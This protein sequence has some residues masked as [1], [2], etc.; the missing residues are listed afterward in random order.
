MSK[1]QNKA[2]Q[3]T[4]DADKLAR[5]EAFVREG[6]WDKIRSTAGRIP[7]S[8]DAVAAYFCAIDRQTPAYIKAMLFGAIAYF[9]MPMDVIPDFIAGL[10]FTDDASVLAATLAAVT[11]H[12]RPEHR[13]KARG[14]LKKETGS[15]PDNN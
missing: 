13:E 5:D 7:F 12:L 10:G 9:I 8:E 6:I 1:Q 2:D 4:Y 3:E 14:V 11:R 15:P